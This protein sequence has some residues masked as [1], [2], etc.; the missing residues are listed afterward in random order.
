MRHMCVR[1]WQTDSDTPLC[2]LPTRIFHSSPSS[3]RPSPPRPARLGLH[4]HHLGRRPPYAGSGDGACIT[5]TVGRDGGMVCGELRGWVSPNT[6]KMSPLDG[7]SACATQ[8]S[9]ASVYGHIWRFSPTPRMLPPQLLPYRPVPPE[10]GGKAVR[11]HARHVSGGAGQC[12]GGGY[13]GLVRPLWGYPADQAAGALID[14]DLNLDLCLDPRCRGGGPGGLVWALGK[15]PA[16]Q[17]S[18]RQSDGS[19]SESRSG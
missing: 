1:G 15:H 3:R 8:P 14:L 4:H 16:D 9:I 12:R 17:A 5:A 6:S 13:G 18:H 19:G 7:H 2:S 10:P 11:A